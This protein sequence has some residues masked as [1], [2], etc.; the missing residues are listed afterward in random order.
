[1]RVKMQISCSP[2]RL[3]AVLGCILA[4]TLMNPDAARAQC[5]TGSDSN[6]AMD[7]LVEQ[8]IDNINLFIVQEENFINQIL[9]NSAFTQLASRF[10]L[11]SQH[12]EEGLTDWWKEFFTALKGMTEELHVAQLDQTRSVGAFMD[13]Q[14]MTQEQSRRGD[15]IINAHRRYA[16]SVLACEIDSAGPGLAKSIQVSRAL[17]RGLAMDDQPRRANAIGSISSADIAHEIDMTWQEYVTK[18]CDNTMGDQGCTTPG[19]IAGKHR[20]I[21]DLLWG[22]KQTID[23]SNKDNLLAMQASLRYLVN[24]LTSGPLLAPVVRADGG[25]QELLVRHAEMGYTNTIYNVL[26]GMLS[27]RIGGSGVNA[28]AM[29]T[30]AG[31]T[32]ADASTNASYRELQETMTRDRYNNPQ[33]VVRMVEDPA[34]VAREQGTL[35]AL[36]LQTMNDLYRRSEEMVFMEA[37]EYSRDLGRQRPGTGAS[38]MKKR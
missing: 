24:P 11:F 13:A 14:L 18:F 38:L 4:L 1:M 15:S 29:R 25:Y 33:Y 34:Q 28:Q 23:P 6:Q 31:I 20:D 16:P 32:P 27:E 36:R 21:P 19:T 3:A 35:N 22:N 10:Q 8:D 9:S 37:A 5:E 7:M 17:N 30:A 12:F 2:I 26:G